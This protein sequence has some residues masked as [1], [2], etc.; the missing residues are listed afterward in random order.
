M[1]LLVARSITEMLLDL[2]FPTYKNPFSPLA[3]LL[4]F[5]ICAEAKSIVKVKTKFED[6]VPSITNTIGIRI[7][8]NKNELFSFFNTI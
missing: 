3:V 2:A 8:R 6:T 5:S 4:S 7:N 1:T